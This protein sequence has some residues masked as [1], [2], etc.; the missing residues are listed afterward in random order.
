MVLTFVAKYLASFPTA[1]NA[2]P[3][4]HPAIC[5]SH[6]FYCTPCFEATQPVPTTAITFLTMPA[7]SLHLPRLYL[8]MLF[9]PRSLPIMNL[10]G[11]HHGLN[12]FMLF[13]LINDE[14]RVFVHFDFLSACYP[15]I[16][17]YCAFYAQVC[18]HS[19]DLSVGITNET[20]VEQLTQDLFHTQ[21]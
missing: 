11:M 9:L 12:R 14:R 13:S 16:A 7:T 3:T 2:H 5:P 21:Q 6:R 8:L 4:H 15:V 10:N 18:T 19:S 20:C 1:I 17:W